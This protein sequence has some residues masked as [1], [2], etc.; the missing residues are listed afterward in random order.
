MKDAKDTSKKSQSCDDLT[1]K[2]VAYEDKDDYVLVTKAESRSKSVEEL[3]GQK[4]TN[5]FVSP[6]VSQE[7]EISHDS[8]V[9][10]IE[11][12]EPTSEVM[13][14]VGTR[15]EKL[16][17]AKEEPSSEDNTEKLSG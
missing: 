11:E 13:M 3:D 16:E 15:A 8:L 5:P 6:K 1:D 7:F 10:P 12:E 9:S 4:T 14:A 17:K 2:N